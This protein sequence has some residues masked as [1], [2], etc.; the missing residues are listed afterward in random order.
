M[1]PRGNFGKMEPNPAILCILAVK[2]E[3]LQHGLLKKYTEFKKK[4]SFGWADLVAAWE[5]SSEPP[6]GTGLNNN[7]FEF[8]D[9]PCFISPSPL[10][11][12][13]HMYLCFFSNCLW[14]SSKRTKKFSE[15]CSTGNVWTICRVHMQNWV[16]LQRLRS[17]R[18]S[19]SCQVWSYW[20]ILWHWYRELC[21]LADEVVSTIRILKMFS[22][23]TTPTK[24]ESSTTGFYRCSKTGFE[25]CKKENACWPPY[26]TCSCHC[27]KA[28][29]SYSQ[30]KHLF[31]NNTLPQKMFS[32][33][34]S[35]HFCGE[36]PSC[37]V[38]LT[39]NLRSKS[40]NIFLLILCPPVR[41][42]NFCK[43]FR[44]KITF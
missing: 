27:Q 21:R 15:E 36:K 12:K 26:Q 23:S 40:R 42:G 24:Q 14:R 30:S 44:K 28:K 34:S 19:E 35:S 32:T 2:T 31:F 5:G 43:T 13:L 41:K 4:F 37:L 17:I 38:F 25:I 39:K 1:L 20:L 18:S 11:F 29:G 9:I 16:Q 7:I 22:F 6:L 8:Y 3:R 10:S 33:F